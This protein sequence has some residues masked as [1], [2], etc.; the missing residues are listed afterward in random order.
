VAVRRDA[1]APAAT[2]DARAL[3][4]ARAAYLRAW[5]ELDQTLSERIDPSRPLWCFGAGEATRM[6]HAYAT[7]ASRA[8]EGYLVDAPDADTFAGRPL[9][10]YRVFDRAFDAS[11]QPQVLLGV[12][13]QAQANVA[14][15]L[16]E[17]GMQP[18]RWDDLVPAT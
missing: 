14:Q 18:I 10:D 4:A 12:R 9:V 17:D 13:P 6:L 5:A 2:S 11:R 15:R 1:G 8:I 7:S 16:R 3:H